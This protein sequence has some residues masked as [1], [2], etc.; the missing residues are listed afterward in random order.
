MP[1]RGIR[2]ATTISQDDQGEVL[3][4]TR[5]L[6]Q[7]ILQANPELQPE[8]IVSII[9][10]VTSDINSVFPAK[11]ARL[12][13]WVNVP[14][15][16]TQEISIPG[17]LPLCIRVLIHWNTDQIQSSIHHVYLRDA[18]NLRPDLSISTY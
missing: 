10:T 8:D 3:T 2:G 13:G 14:L 16:C 12:L 4:A 18:V 15:L 5:E 9:F 17:S 6:L 7:A 11:A 1:V